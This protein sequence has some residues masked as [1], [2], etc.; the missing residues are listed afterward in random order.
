MK[1]LFKYLPN[2]I[3]N[4]IV[5]NYGVYQTNIRYKRNLGKP[6]SD[7]YSN[8]TVED[9][10][11]INILL[12]S[13]VKHAVETVPFYK[14]IYRLDPF[15]IENFTKDDLV[16]AFP[17]INKEIVQEN[18]NDFISEDYKMNS[19]IEMRTSGTTGSPGRYF[20]SKGDR[21][22]N[23]FFFRNILK[24][25]GADYNSKSC[26]IAARPIGGIKPKQISNMDYYN[27][28]LYLSS[29][30]FNKDTIKY[31]IEA[32]NKFKPIYIDSFPS[33][34]HSIV[35]LAEA[36]GLK[37]NFKLRFLILSS[38]TISEKH[39]IAIR[40]FF[41]D[42]ILID[43]YGSVEMV[44]SLW[45]ADRA[46]FHL[47]S[48]YSIPE[49]LDA[50]NGAFNFIST[51]L[52]RKAMPLIRYDTNDLVHLNKKEEVVEIIGRVEDTIVTPN[53]NRV[54]RFDSIYKGIEGIN[55][56]QVVQVRTDLIEVRIVVTSK[57]NSND[58][59]QIKKNTE[60][61]LQDKVEVKVKC[62]SEIP[63][64]KS[65]KFKAVVSL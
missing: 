7:I 31:Y 32:L 58:E 52:I 35:L 45:R 8:N 61:Y 41:K 3:Q 30:K 37:L 40:R 56:G 19:L 42:P 46:P 63:R 29:F 5:S 59:L 57:F 6:Y 4:T 1:N 55:E 43:Q 39:R 18:L 49:F 36:Q 48:Y 12:R 54:Q 33:S 10:E 26:T 20:A 13:I 21:A 24:S 15:K 2:Y 9:E 27:N 28:T 16:N 23:Y 11:K 44:A 60:Y 50:E 34:I 47:D 25:L 38:E 14:K 53:G 62:V 22:R 64:T 51:S 65:G 17:V